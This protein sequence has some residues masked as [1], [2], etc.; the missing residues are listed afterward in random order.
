MP[1]YLKS[2]GFPNPQNALDGP[3]QHANK[4][5]SAFAWLSEH[6]D[7]FQAFHRYVH[8]LRL[9]TPSWMEMYPV[10]ERLVEGLKPDGDTSSSSSAFVDI[11]GGTGQML[12]D[13]RARIPQYTGKVVLQEIP[14]VI[15]ATAKGVGTDAIELQEHDFFKPQPVNGA[16][17]YFMR[18][19]MHDWPDEQCR[20]ILGH[21]K[22]AMEP[23]YSRILIND[24]VC[25]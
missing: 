8:A 20:Q 7:V 10:Q 11:G 23:G 9:H 15:A 1:A 18:Y 16:R 25:E 24:C 12:Q 19:V 2:N 3:F 5:G 13:F 14:D 22:D 17:A 21:I 4:C 6:P